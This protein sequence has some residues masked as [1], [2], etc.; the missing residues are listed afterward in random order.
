MLPSLSLPPLE[1]CFGTS[2][3]Q[4]E[5]F[6]PDRKAFGS[7]TLATRAVASAGPTPG[8]A[9]SRLLVSL[10][11]CQ[12]VI[13]R[14]N[15]KICALSIRSWAPRAARHARAISRTRLSL[16]S[17]T[18]PSSSSTPLRPTAATIPYSARWARIALI[19]AVCWRMKRWRVRWSIRQLCCSSVLVTA[20][21]YITC[22]V[23]SVDLKNRLGDIETN[24]RDRL[25]V[26]LL[27]IVGAL[28]APTSMALPCRWR[29]RPQHQ[30]RPNALQQKSTAIR[31]P[32]GER[33]RGCNKFPG[34]QS[35]SQPS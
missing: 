4:A 10:D 25:H 19:T 13:I 34:P 24:C 23:N 14:S 31:S 22:R 15:S 11:R 6:R 35:D 3:I 21:D 17:A 29:S 27:R 30:E 12:A 33:E 5:K 20:N 2:P 18:T 1:C 28:T 8:I 26:W 32:V 9:S 7:G 16:G